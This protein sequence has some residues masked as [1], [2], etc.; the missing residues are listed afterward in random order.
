MYDF[1]EIKAAMADPKTLRYGTEFRNINLSL[2]FNHDSYREAFDAHEQ[3]V[4]RF[5]QDKPTDR[6][7]ELNIFAG[8]GW[9]ELCVFLGKDVPSIPFP[10]ENREPSAPIQP[11]ATGPAPA[12]N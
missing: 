5:F 12:K 6:L 4:R 2:Y 7:L 8:D 11:L 3:R 10:W 1:D 9:P